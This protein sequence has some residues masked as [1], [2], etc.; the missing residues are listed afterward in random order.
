MVN[1][2]VEEALHQVEDRAAMVRFFADAIRQVDVVPD[3]SVFSR[4]ADT[5]GEIETTSAPRAGR[6]TSMSSASN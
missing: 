1:L 4:L 3:R 6:S 2:I 5:L